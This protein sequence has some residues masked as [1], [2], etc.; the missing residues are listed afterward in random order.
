MPAQS[1]DCFWLG[2]PSSIARNSAAQ[3]EGHSL[4]VRLYT[5]SK[6]K[7]NMCC[8]LK[9]L[10]SVF[11]GLEK[12]I[13]GRTCTYRVFCCF[14]CSFSELLFPQASKS[15]CKCVSL[16]G[17]SNRLLFHMRSPGVYSWGWRHQRW[18]LQ[19]LENDK[20]CALG[21]KASS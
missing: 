3:A 5:T 6:W 10:G 16:R 18:T 21:P 19:L 1:S 14:P 17:F 4:L 9:S 12:T 20:Y 11:H 13:G 8:A 7:S 15:G 2:C